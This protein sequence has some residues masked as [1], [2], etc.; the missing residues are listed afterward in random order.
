M[1]QDITVGIRL[2]AD[3]KGFAGEMRLAGRELQRLTGSTDHAGAAARRL[4]R[5]TGQAEAATRRASAGFLAAHNR[6]L[7]YAGGF[8]SVGSALGAMRSATRPVHPRAGV[9][10]PRGPRRDDLHGHGLRGV[11]GRAERVDGHRAPTPGVETRSRPGPSRVLVSGVHRSGWWPALTG[12]L[13]DDANVS[14]SCPAGCCNLTM[15]SNAGQ[16]VLD[17][18]LNH[19][20]EPLI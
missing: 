1:P 18:P 6:L 14:A 17:G 10:Q 16:M 15:P 7:R 13:C 9:E 8:L 4:A 20:T 19:V 5:T 12:G 3:G 11:A 2:A